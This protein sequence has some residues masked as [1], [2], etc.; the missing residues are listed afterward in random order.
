M[1]IEE[2]LRVLPDLGEGIRRV[3]QRPLGV[4][5][6]VLGSPQL[7]RVGE[8]LASEPQVGVGFGGFDLRERLRGQ[9]LVVGPVAAS[10]SGPRPS[11]R[12]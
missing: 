2:T 4:G 6:R 11:H 10:S 8:D 7:G 12:V 3:R 9:P 5:E 1:L